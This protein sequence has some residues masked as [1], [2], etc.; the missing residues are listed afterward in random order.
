MKWGPRTPSIKRMIAA[1]L[2]PARFIRHNLG[3]KA[4]RGFGR[5]TNPKKALYNRIYS[6]ITFSI[7]DVFKRPKE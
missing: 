1:R 7:F 6:R 3:L 2:S 5:V 4:P